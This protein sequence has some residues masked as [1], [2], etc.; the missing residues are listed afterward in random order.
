MI[1]QNLF[2]KLNQAILVYDSATKE[3]ILS[4]PAASRALEFTPDELLSKKISELHPELILKYV[5]PIFNSMIEEKTN[6]A[7]SIPF[8]TKNN[9][10]IYFD[11]Y[12][13]NMKLGSKHCLV[14]ILFNSSAKSN[15]FDDNL[16]YKLALNSSTDAIIITDNSGRIN[17][18]NQKASSLLRLNNESHLEENNAFSMIFSANEEEKNTF[19]RKAIASEKPKCFEWSVISDENQ[20]VSLEVSISLMRELDSKKRGFIIIARDI[21]D[22][23]RNED[24][25]KKSLEDKDFLLKEIHHRVKNNL[26]VIHSILSLQSRYVNSP[27]IIKVIEESQDRIKS[28][29]FIHEYLYQSND[30][31]KIDMNHYIEK[32]CEYLHLSYSD[33]NKHIRI[34]MNSQNLKVDLQTATPCGLII[35]ELVSNSLKHAFNDVKQGEIEITFTLTQNEYSLIVKDNGKGFPDE[36]NMHSSNS[37]GIRLIKILTEQLKGEVIFK[38]TRGAVCEIKFPNV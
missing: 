23:K 28:M 25:I 7:S 8:L 33:S 35:N 26:Q 2:E 27:E 37:L 4:N 6:S 20:I 22:R 31:T 38:N 16:I 34:K 1:Y 19:I 29:S 36:N 12:A 13:S 18:L 11:V 21:S 17:I 14:F 24:E 9:D 15:T 32:L 30:I 5:E 3:V 10:L